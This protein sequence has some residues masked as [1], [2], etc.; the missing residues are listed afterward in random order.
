[1]NDYVYHRLAEIHI[2]EL[3]R[4]AEQERLVAH[5]RRKRRHTDDRLKQVSLFAWR[6]RWRA[7]ATIS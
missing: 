6:K 2:E 4:E 5:A 1:M 7:W 3:R